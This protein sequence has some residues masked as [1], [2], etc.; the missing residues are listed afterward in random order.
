MLQTRNH[1]TSSPTPAARPV[2]WR[3]WLR[4]ARPFSLS[5]ALSPVLVGT[6][7]AAYDG[8]FTPL[9]FAATLLA[10]VFL[11]VGTNF[12]NEYFDHRYGLDTD[13]SLGA[14]TV[15]F[16]GEM[17]PA[18]VLGGGIASFVLAAL[19]GLVLILAVGPQILLFGLAAMAI[20]YFYSARPFK[21]A[22]RGLGD[23]L[24]YLAMGLLMTWGAY[25]VQIHAWSWSAFAASV[26][27]GFLVVAILN[28]NNLRDYPDDLAVHK[29]TVVVRFGMPFGRRYQ[30]ALV[31]GAY[32]ATTI[33]AFA[34][35]LPLAALA[36][37]L[38]LPL[39]LGIVRIAL[40]ATDRKQFIPGMKRISLLHLLF[41]LVLAAAITLAAVLH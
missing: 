18:Q 35:L 31:L 37:W 36:V 39:A 3:I 29:R 23:P 4:T 11:Q 20:G 10:S 32:L 21:L 8:V 40:T 13:Q 33:F 15:I 6:A 38:T 27:V 2:S 28:M 34:G 9:T 19:F 5:A 1:P 12:F 25:Y 14:S 16:R 17:T 26:P 41:G 22:S 7:V 24:V 30:A